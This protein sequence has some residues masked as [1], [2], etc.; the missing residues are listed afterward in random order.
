MPEIDVFEVFTIASFLNFKICELSFI[1]NS[2]FDAVAQF[3]R[4]QKLYF[5]REV[6]AY[7]SRELA[8]IELALWK[9]QQVIFKYLM[10]KIFNYFSVVCLLNYLSVP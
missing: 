2:A 4:H 10:H 8:V 6:G 3:Q 9:S 7:P 5:D 1:H